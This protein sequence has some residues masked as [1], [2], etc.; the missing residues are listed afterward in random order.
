[1]Y[2]QPVKK[3]DSLA[4]TSIRLREMLNA[5]PTLPGGL[6]ICAAGQIDGRGRFDRKWISPAGDCLTFSALLRID[7]PAEYLL[8]LPMVVSVAV[9]RMLKKLNIDAKLKWPN[10]VLV[11]N[12]KIC[13]ILCENVSMKNCTVPAAIIGV[14][15][16][17]NLSADA[18][19]EISQPA[20]SMLIETS[21]K[22]SIDGVLNILLEA[23]DAAVSA[24]AGEGFV[25]ARQTWLANT[26][27]IGRDVEIHSTGEIFR[28]TIIGLGRF[29]QLLVKDA[30]GVSRE[31]LEGDVKV[32]RQ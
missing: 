19:A 27:D 8:S 21:Q 5:D 29:G 26:D 30:E 20:T 6:V 10:D 2:F 31:I 11:N 28:G 22:Y 24:W 4:S 23:L 12:R 7:V 15:L 13:G 14:G 16:N 9:T 3:F 17:V 32:T 18:A 25:A 1:M